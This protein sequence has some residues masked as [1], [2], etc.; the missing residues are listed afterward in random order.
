MQ[1]EQPSES[2]QNVTNRSAIEILQFKVIRYV[3]GE[4]HRLHSV[5]YFKVMKE[6]EFSASN[7]ALANLAFKGSELA[8]ILMAVLFCKLQDKVTPVFTILAVHLK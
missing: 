3:V 5:L 1:D 2:M 7:L 4:I 8:L 6:I